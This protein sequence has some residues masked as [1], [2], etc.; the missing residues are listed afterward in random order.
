MKRNLM[1]NTDL[2]D[3]YVYRVYIVQPTLPRVSG[4]SQWDALNYGGAG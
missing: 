4:T 2:F 3:I 1:I